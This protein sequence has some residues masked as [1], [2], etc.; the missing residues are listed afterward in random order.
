MGMALAGRGRSR[1][2]IG[3]WIR[4]RIAGDAIGL[5]AT[6][7]LEFAA[8]RV[9][10]GTGGSEWDLGLAALLAVLGA[11]VG[12]AWV[13]AR[14][15]WA[16]LSTSSVT[17]H[18]EG[19]RV[20]TTLGYA[21][22]SQG[23]KVIAEKLAASGVRFVYERRRVAT[24]GTSRVPDF[25]LWDEFG[26]EWYLEHLGLLND[27]QYAARWQASERWYDHRFPGR[28][29]VTLPGDLE[30]QVVRIIRALQA[31]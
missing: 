26:G 13:R 17:L 4:H 27:P 1:V 21:V 20:A 6:I 9:L 10:T 18:P 31:A 12:V 15:E 7:G 29:L 16:S 22:R 5:A 28:L 2:G 23:E 19:R 30:G 11:I 8:V 14:R 24:D 3:W 25:T